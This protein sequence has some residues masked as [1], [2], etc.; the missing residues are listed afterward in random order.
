LEASPQKNTGPGRLIAVVLGG[1]GILALMLAEYEP[2]VLES[3]PVATPTVVEA[4][5][6][7]PVVAPL[8]TDSGLRN[9]VPAALHAALFAEDIP[10]LQRLLESGATLESRDAQ[11]RTPLMLA[12]QLGDAEA[13]E[14]LLAQSANPDATDPF[15]DTALIWAV[16]QRRLDL[17]D[18]LLKQ[19]ADPDK[20]HLTPLMWAALHNELLILER[21]LEA[22]PTI[23]LRTRDG[24][25]VMH[26]AAE[27][28]ATEVMWR[29]LRSGA[30]VNAQD[31]AGRTALM[32]AAR[33]GHL[34]TVRLLLER[35]ALRDVED[36]EG[37]TAL[38][39]AEAS[40]R[41][42]IT[43]LLLR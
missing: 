17:V 25:T 34:T 6:T 3:P 27:K 11:H 40:G 32:L 9:P 20:G 30:V 24:W 42:E 1:L 14:L 8:A 29:L 31:Q 18:L 43:E 16:V 28:G 38:D 22:Q 36:F 41:S 5:E 19:H 12:V 21:I 35:G 39:W 15:G 23:N 4:E 2:V 33:R 26:W 10:A 13:A 7:L 37:Q